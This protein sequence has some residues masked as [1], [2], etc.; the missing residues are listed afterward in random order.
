MNARRNIERTPSESGPFQFTHHSPENALTVENY[1]GGVIICASR[2]N[3]S[4][5]QR[6]LFIDYLA[7][8]GFIPDRYRSGSNQSDAATVVR[9]QWLVSTRGSDAALQT[10]T[11]ARRTA[12]FLIGLFAF[13]CLIWLLQLAVLF[14]TRP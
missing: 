9:V 12:R 1:P 10:A 14:L 11:A 6:Q 13:V 3:F 2:D 5:R 4:L 8:E 7:T